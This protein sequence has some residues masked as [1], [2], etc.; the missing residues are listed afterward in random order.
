VGPLSSNA[1]RAAL[2]GAVT[3]AFSA[4]LVRLAGVSPST[5]AV[6]RCAYAVPALGLLAWIE[7]RRFGPRSRR[8][9]A[10]GV[11]AG[12]VFAADLLFWHHSI[13][14]VGAGLATVLGNLQ[15]VIVAFAAWAML[16][17][18]PGRRVLV[19]IPVALV[20]IVLI[21]G[22][23]G[24]GAYGKDP[25]LGV[26][27]GVLTGIAYSAFILILRETGRDLRRLAGPLF[28]AT[29]SAAVFAAVAGAII[30]D[31]DLTPSWPA[32]GWLLVL[33]LSSQV[34][35]WLL[36]A[37]SLPR[38]PAAVSSVLLTIQPL[39][40]VILGVVLL[41][42]RPTALQL[43]GAACIFSGVLIAT[44]RPVRRESEA[45]AAPGR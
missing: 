29:A 41:G 43:A 32:H 30:G 40:S 28:D 12:A 13:A 15:V 26:L 1:G 11:V 23:I 24:H 4:I 38:L 14:D 10:L 37:A 21:S 34:V 9:H 3:I 27:F 20:G 5:A 18:R 25:A 35:G 17:E 22:V 19:A 16:G 33:A 45:M 44:V 42:E 31:V 7:R 2:A 6:F 39:G 36:I 8:E